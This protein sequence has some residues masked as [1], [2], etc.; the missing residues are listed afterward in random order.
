M[1]SKVTQKFKKDNNYSNV[2]N[3]YTMFKVT[4]MLTTDILK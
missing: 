1:D 4:M 3:V 2:N